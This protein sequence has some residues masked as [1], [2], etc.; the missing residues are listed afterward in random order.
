M[1]KPAILEFRNYDP[2]Q[3]EKGMFFL[4]GNEEEG[5]QITE[6]Q[7]DVEDKEAFVKEA[8]YP[9][10]PYIIET[11]NNNSVN[12]LANPEQIGWIDEGAQYDSLF[13]IDLQILNF[14]IGYYLGNILI[15]IDENTGEPTFYDNKITLR[16]DEDELYDEELV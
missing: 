6:L 15:E 7:H 10:L 1:F 12:V 5:F 4:I 3:I 14:I 8:G 9:V 16:Y 2:P 13:E 11:I